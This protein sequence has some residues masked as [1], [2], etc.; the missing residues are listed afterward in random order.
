MESFIVFVLLPVS[1]LNCS[2]LDSCRDFLTCLSDSRGLG[3]DAWIQEYKRM[4]EV[5]SESE[6]DESML[7]S[8]QEYDEDL[9]DAES[10]SE[11]VWCLRCQRFVGE[12]PKCCGACGYD[13]QLVPQQT[14]QPDGEPVAVTQSDES[15]DLVSLVSADA[16]EEPEM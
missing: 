12:D 13:D 7:S 16:G 10:N 1:P 11:R 15:L 14:P 4:G 5:D 8:E 3:F 6:N 9:E 2:M